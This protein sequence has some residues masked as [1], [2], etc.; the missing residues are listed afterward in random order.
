MPRTRRMGS[1]EPLTFLE[2]P[3]PRRTRRKRTPAR[4]ES[5]QPEMSLE[6]TTVTEENDD[7][8]QSTVDTTQ[9]TSE[10]DPQSGK[11]T[12]LYCLNA[13]GMKYAVHVS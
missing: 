3:E 7:P 11:T 8:T 6:M 13:V 2:D 5:V 10:E 4:D 1:E 9:V 12:N